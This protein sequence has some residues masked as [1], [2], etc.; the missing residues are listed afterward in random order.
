MFFNYK[1]KAETNKAKIIKND[2]KKFKKLCL[3]EFKLNISRGKT[4]R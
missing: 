3:K 2:V 1:Q 4:I